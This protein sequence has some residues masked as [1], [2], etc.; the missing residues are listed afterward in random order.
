MS[1]PVVIRGG[2]DLASGVALRLYRSG[3]RPLVTELPQPLVV[4]RRVA[5]AE[6]IYDGLVQ[7]E[8]VT[9]RRVESL[10]QAQAAVL[11]DE[12]PVLADPDGAALEQLVQAGRG[13]LAWAAAAPVGS[14]MHAGVFSTAGLADLP[15]VP[16]PAGAVPALAVVDARMTKRPPEPLDLASIFLVGLGPG[17]TAGLDCQAVVET[18]RGHA[19]GRVIW[20]G[21]TE[22][23]TGVPELV[24]G[25]SSERVL[26]APADGGLQALAEIGARVEAGQVLAQVAGREVVAPFGGVLRGLVRSGLP[27]ARGM[28]IG[29]VDPRGD[30]QACFLVSD[31]ALAVGGAVLEALLSRP[32]VRRALWTA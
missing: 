24:G 9:G 28:K 14:G 26:R 16:A 12:I 19:L 3:L 22:P 30:P 18:N 1:L 6:A 15:A 23:D 13:R 27:V 32:E 8:G 21:M 11:R 29:D 17:F 2:G 7:V 10:E 4:R 25:R 31:K 20:R 5:F